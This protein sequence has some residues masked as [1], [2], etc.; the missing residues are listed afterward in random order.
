MD[1]KKIDPRL[2]GAIEETAG[3]LRKPYD[4]TR[5]KAITKW[6]DIS[7]WRDGNHIGDW[8][9]IESGAFNLLGELPNLHTLYFPYGFRHKDYT[10]LKTCVKLKKLDLQ[11]T[12]FQDCSLLTQ[13]PEL[14]SVHLPHKKQLIHT[15]VLDELKA[16]IQFSDYY[17][18][19]LKQAQ[20]A[21]SMPQRTLYKGDTPVEALLENF[22]ARTK[23][24]AYRLRVQHDAV[25][26]LTSSKIGGLPYWDLSQSYPVDVK[27]K[28]MQLLAQINFS[29][30]EMEPPFPKT[31]LLQFFVAQDDM[32]GCNFAYAPDQ[33]NYRVV[34][35]SKIDACVT[36]DQVSTLGAPGIVDDYRT[37]PLTKE[38]P[39]H[40]EQADSF[41]NDRSFIFEDAF[42]ATV[43]DV[44]GVDMGEQKSFQFLDD[45]AYE[46]LFESQKETDDGC[47]NG[48]HWMLGYPSFTQ[49]DPRSEDSPFD[50]LLLQ[51]D[52]MRDEDGSCPIL[53]GDCGVANF[54]IAKEDLERLDFSRVLYNWDC[55]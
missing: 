12:D 18:G 20:S 37:S 31:G 13:L 51:I 26:G 19:K 14:R 24:P 32:F 34:Y 17:A 50:T 29:Q 53:W 27:G 43:K 5:V 2:L 47:M 7:P 48:G 52:S 35:H 25:P 28:P 22:N 10:F 55:C 46:V 4:L 38:L 49:E 11:Y 36:A 21:Q 15:E 1:M 45:E 42:K 9:E 44:M 3:F 40:A 39:I 54:F 23:V 30:E 41:A 33:K 8:L 16:K 6:P